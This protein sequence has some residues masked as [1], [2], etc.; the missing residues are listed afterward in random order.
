MNQLKGITYQCGT[1][2]TLLLFYRNVEKGKGSSMWMRLHIVPKV[3]I[4]KK[5]KKKKQDPKKIKLDLK[6][7]KKNCVVS[8]TDQVYHL[9]NCYIYFFLLNRPL[10]LAY[11][12]N[13]CLPV[14]EWLILKLFLDIDH[15]IINLVRNILMFGWEAFYLINSFQK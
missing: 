3:E 10:I 15:V 8:V 14:Y 1:L 9:D 7:S 5:K 4:P 11:L 2:T 6:S 13:L 12:F